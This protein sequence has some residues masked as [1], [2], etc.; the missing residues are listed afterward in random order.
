MRLEANEAYGVLGCE[1]GRGGTERGAGR[2]EGT[3]RERERKK[4]L[5]EAHE[6]IERF[7]S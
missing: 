5:V 7:D 1:R 2:S 3:K 4:V 6:S